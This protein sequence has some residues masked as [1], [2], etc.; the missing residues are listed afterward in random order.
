MV[1][2]GLQKALSAFTLEAQAALAERAWAETT[3]SGAL[4]QIR[5]S[6]RKRDISRAFVHATSLSPDKMKRS[7]CLIK[8]LFGRLTTLAE[9]QE[10]DLAYVQAE[11]VCQPERRVY[12]SQNREETSQEKVGGP[13][14]ILRKDPLGVLIFPKVVCFSPRNIKGLWQGH[15]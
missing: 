12:I 7:S 1:A 15:P 9:T 14:F 13:P 5:K 6:F 4:P 11:H 3:L 8:T 10:R 2:N